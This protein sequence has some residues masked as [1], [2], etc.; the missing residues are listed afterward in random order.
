VIRAA[1]LRRSGIAVVLS[2]TLGA[3]AV[4]HGSPNGEIGHALD[5]ATTQN[6][7]IVRMLD[8]KVGSIYR[9]GFPILTNTTSANVAVEFVRLAHVPDGLT[10]I[11][12]AA[13]TATSAAGYLLNQRFDNSPGPGPIP[14]KGRVSVG[15]MT[16]SEH[17]YMVSVRV[18]RMTV[19]PM[20]GCVVVYSQNG[21][22]YAQT[23]SC[24]FQ[25]AP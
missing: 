21:K 1:F 7:S 20:R 3:C 14:Y 13:F 17:F 10:V 23:L 18:D 5:N 9:F 4:V 22:E 24:E 19:E 16:T 25:L 2:S 11:G 8:A 6:G 15:A 12:Y